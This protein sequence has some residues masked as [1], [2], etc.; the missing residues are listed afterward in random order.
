MFPVDA[1]STGRKL[2]QKYVE[3]PARWEPMYEITQ[4]KG[5][6]EAHAFLSPDDAFADC[7]TGDAGRRCQKAP[8]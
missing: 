8:A 6:G 2:D 5:D 1:Q 7:E 4:I 3:S